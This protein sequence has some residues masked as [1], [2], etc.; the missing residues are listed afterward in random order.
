MGRPKEVVKYL[1]GGTLEPSG[2]QE[3]HAEQE[4]DSRQRICFEVEASLP[5]ISR[6]GRDSSTSLG[7]TIYLL[8]HTSQADVPGEQD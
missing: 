3:C 4:T 1:T 8:F 7:M 5:D 2:K 6:R